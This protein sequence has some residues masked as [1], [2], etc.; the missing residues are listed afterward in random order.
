[1]H[2]TLALLVL[3][4]CGGPALDSGSGIDRACDD[5]E[6]FD[7]YVSGLSR[8]TLE[9]TFGMAV[10]ADPA[11]PD[12]GPVAFTFQV[13]DAAGPLMDGAVQI[14]P[15]MPLH[16]HGSVP[17]I[18][19]GVPDGAGGYAVE[20]VDLFMAGLWEIHVTVTSAETTDEGLYR[21]CLEG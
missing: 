11:P 8:D 18:L 5:G 15:F 10:T 14:R 9:G 17:E 6:P 20:A 3:A 19:E 4:G 12:V 7:E 16:G 2:K 21:F 1:M 13:T